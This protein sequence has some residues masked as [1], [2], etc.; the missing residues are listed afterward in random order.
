L[1]CHIAGKGE[2]VLSG[3][4]VNGTETKP[5]I[6]QITYL[7]SSTIWSANSKA[8]AVFEVDKK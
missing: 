2:S 7:I 6:L 4:L 8:P 5:S 1:C 3:Q